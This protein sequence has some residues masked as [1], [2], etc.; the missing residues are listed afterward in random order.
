MGSFTSLLAL[1]HLQDFI[2]YAYTFCTGIL[3]LQSLL[4]FCVGWLEALGDLAHY[5]LA[6]AAM[7]TYS[8]GLGPEELTHNYCL[9]CPIS[10]TSQP[11]LTTIFS[12]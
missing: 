3:E 2:Y 11:I 7:V 10:W 12:T 9:Y 4:P 6:V 1:E 8:Q 5:Y